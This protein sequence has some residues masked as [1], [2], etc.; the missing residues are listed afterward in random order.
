MSESTSRTVKGQRVV[1]GGVTVTVEM[2]HGELEI[3]V[4]G[5]DREAEGEQVVIGRRWGKGHGT[6]Y[7]EGEEAGDVSGHRFVIHDSR[8][9]ED[10][11]ARLE[12]QAAE[13]ARV[14]TLYSE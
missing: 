6:L 7:V 9:E 8:E 13:L 12:Q 1:E 14:S 10:R 11:L 3:R 2:N 4:S 5:R